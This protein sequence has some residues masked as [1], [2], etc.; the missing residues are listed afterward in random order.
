[1]QGKKSPK[2]NLLGHKSS[3]IDGRPESF[4]HDFFNWESLL[5]Q[6]NSTELERV[7]LFW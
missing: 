1:L 6:L 5:K 3:L 4:E 2:L 7:D